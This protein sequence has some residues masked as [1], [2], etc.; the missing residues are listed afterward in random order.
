MAQ[1]A[2]YF[3]P[4]HNQKDRENRNR[5][6]KTYVRTTLKFLIQVGNFVYLVG[7]VGV[8]VCR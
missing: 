7:P 8:L 2:I 5:S 6:N 3:A 4:N 1:P